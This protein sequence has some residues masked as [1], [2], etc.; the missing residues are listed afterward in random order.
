MGE[1]L[2]GSPEHEFQPMLD[3]GMVL[4]RLFELREELGIDI[5]EADLADL[6]GEDDNDFMGNLTTL[7]L[8]HGIDHE[9]MFDRLGIS[10][11]S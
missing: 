1:R 7:A 6:M 3:R 9:D 11:E 10:T 8:E 4:D 2:S 5:E